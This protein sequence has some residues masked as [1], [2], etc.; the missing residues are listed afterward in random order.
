MVLIFWHIT[1]LMPYC[2]DEEHMRVQPLSAV[3]AIATLVALTGSVSAEDVGPLL[4]NPLIF[5]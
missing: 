5:R 4:M 1:T 3:A 2:S